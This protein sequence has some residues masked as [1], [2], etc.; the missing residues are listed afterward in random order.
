MPELE[1]EEDLGLSINDLMLDLEPTEEDDEEGT[2][3]DED[4]VEE[5]R[6]EEEEDGEEEQER[7]KSPTLAHSTNS[8]GQRLDEKTYARRG[9]LPLA[10]LAQHRGSLISDILLSKEKRRKSRQLRAPGYKDKQGFIWRRW[11]R[12]GTSPPINGTESKT[13]EGEAMEA[14]SLTVTEP[15]SSSLR[16]FSMD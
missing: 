3:Q 4:D 8:L 7:P 13:K 15:D 5:E 6:D 2:L 11:E 16:S 9:S 14:P 12:G 1:E 10:L